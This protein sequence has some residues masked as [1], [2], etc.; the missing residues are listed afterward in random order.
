MLD[1]IVSSTDANDNVKA[2]HELEDFASQAYK[3]TE[4]KHR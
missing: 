4:T 3:N 2:T 1:S